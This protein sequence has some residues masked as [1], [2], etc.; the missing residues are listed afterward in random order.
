MFKLKRLIFFSD[1]IT[2]NLEPISTKYI[3]HFWKIVGRNNFTI[4]KAVR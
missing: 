4:T 2:D 1:N 3:I